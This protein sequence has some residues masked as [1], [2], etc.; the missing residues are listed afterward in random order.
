MEPGQEADADA[1]EDAPEGPIVLPAEGEAAEG[2][3]GAEARGQ[4]GEDE[5]AVGHLRVAEGEGAP[6][7]QGD[8]LAA[9]RLEGE[10]EDLHGQQR[11]EDVDLIDDHRPAARR[12]VE[13]V[14]VDEGRVDRGAQHPTGHDQH[15]E[16]EAVLRV[17]LVLRPV[18]R[19]AVVWRQRPGRR[20]A[21]EAG[22][23]AHARVKE[24]L[25]LMDVVIQLVDVVVLHDADRGVQIEGLIAGRR[26]GVDEHLVRA[27]RVDDQGD[28]EDGDGPEHVDARRARGGRLRVKRRARRGRH[29]RERG[30]V[31]CGRLGRGQGFGPGLRIRPARLLVRF[32]QGHARGCSSRPGALAGRGRTVA[33]YTI[34][35]RAAPRIAR[36]A[37][38]RLLGRGPACRSDLA[39]GAPPGGALPGS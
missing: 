39:I 10:Q 2:V 23:V 36:A 21:L 37:P 14:Q 9:R 26:L 16:A 3:D 30:R 15:A 27:Q 33:Y 35:P 38:A 19:V 5:V 17:P 4:L 11:A 28:D 20:D 1:D 29:G 18:N 7:R 8:A 31:R 25:V 13:R 24:R 6:D 34:P 22:G 32:V 12:Q